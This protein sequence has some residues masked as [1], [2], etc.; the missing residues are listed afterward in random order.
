M[1]VARNT[2]YSNGVSSGP[3]LAKNKVKERLCWCMCLYVWARARPVRN[4]SHTHS[5]MQTH[6]KA[7]SFVNKHD[8]CFPL[9]EV[10]FINWACNNKKRGAHL[11]NKA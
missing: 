3:L 6:T 1:S 5:H 9:Q 4:N 11:S 10:V 2:P 8:V 7:Q